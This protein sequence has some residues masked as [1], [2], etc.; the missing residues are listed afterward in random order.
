MKLRSG[1]LASLLVL[2]AGL[3]AGTSSCTGDGSVIEENQHALVGTPLPIADTYVRDGMY[4]AN[5]YGRESTVK[6]RKADSGY[7]RWAYFKFDTSSI[8]GTLARATLV[9]YGSNGVGSCSIAAYPV[10]ADTW[11]EKVLTWYKR[12]DTSSP[13]L[14]TTLVGPTEDSYYW[15]VT[16]YVNAERAQG[17]TTVA[18]L[19]KAVTESEQLASFHSREAVDGKPYLSMNTS[20]ATGSTTSV[21]TA[22]AVGTSIGK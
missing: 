4:A 9:L 10:P 16:A 12:V 18:L 1:H 13:A 17:R 19:L 7:N 15:D 22:T 21:H 20:V 6:V 2:A 11:T 3:C 5:S 14:S 8:S